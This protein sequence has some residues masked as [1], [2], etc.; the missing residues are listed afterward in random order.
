M[1]CQTCGHPRILDLEGTRKQAALAD[2]AQGRAA[3]GLLDLVG[4]VER[5]RWNAL[6]RNGMLLSIV[7]L[8]YG[9]K[10][11]SFS[12][13]VFGNDVRGGT[14]FFTLSCMSAILMSNNADRMMTLIAIVDPNLEL[15]S[16]AAS[17]DVGLVRQ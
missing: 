15:H 5:A 16:A 17:G 10:A 2:P 9:F 7:S 13:I 3:Q 8:V 1:Q 6:K 11:Q 14:D 12:A 4:E